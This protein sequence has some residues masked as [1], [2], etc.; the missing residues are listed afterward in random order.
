MNEFDKFA[1]EAEGSLTYVLVNASRAKRA[2]KTHDPLALVENTYASSLSSRSPSAYYVTHPPSVIGYDD[3]YHREA[4]CVDHEDS[5]TT[6]M[7]LFA[8]EITQRHS[9]PTNNHLH[10]SSNTRNQAIVQADRVDIQSKTVRNSGR[11]VRRITDNQ[12]DSARNVNVEKDTGNTTNTQRILRT[13]TNSG[14][15]LM[16]NAITAMPKATMQETV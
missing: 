8:R 14:M 4:I 3:D 5:L 16:F 11:Y 2:A 6:A 15:L 7:M 12:G 9:K 1:Y 13:V 10:T